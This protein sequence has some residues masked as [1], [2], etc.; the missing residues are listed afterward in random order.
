MRLKIQESSISLDELKSVLQNE[1][2]IKYQIKTRQKGM[3]AVVK[4]KTSA[5]L[6]IITKKKLI[7][8]GGFPNMK[9]QM[10]FTI[11]IVLL[12]FILPLLIYFFFFHKKMKKIENE[13]GNYLKEKYKDK[14]IGA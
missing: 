5:A 10:I 13:V 11:L 8:N 12:G 2:G 3:L 6:I 7:I 4:T 14:I 1:F 9:S